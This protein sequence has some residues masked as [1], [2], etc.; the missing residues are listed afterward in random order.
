MRKSVIKTFALLL[1]VLVI[2]LAIL[3]LLRS[4]LETFVSPHSGV[5]VLVKLIS[6][7]DILVECVA[8]AIAVV[9]A[10]RLASL[11]VCLAVVEG[12]VVVPAPVGAARFD[13]TLRH[14]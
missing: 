11:R 9:R 4:T 3:C 8:L 12:T 6:L 10:H 2:L 7:L 13:V 5:E 1:V 14:G